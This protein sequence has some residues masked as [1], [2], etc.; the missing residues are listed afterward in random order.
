MKLGKGFKI[1]GDPNLG[2]L[3]LDGYSRHGGDSGS[4]PRLEIAA[5]TN[6]TVATLASL[7]Y[8]SHGL[9]S[10]RV[11][12]GL[13]VGTGTNAAVMMDLSCLHQSKQD[14]IKLPAKV[15]KAH[16]RVMINTEWSLWG[17]IGP[18]KD[19]GLVTKW[20]EQLDRE[21]DDPGFMP[22]EYMTGG[23]YLGEMVRLVAYDYFVSQQKDNP[24]HLPQHLRV[25]AGLH[26]DYLSDVI[27]TDMS[28]DELLSSLERDLPASGDSFRWTSENA[29]MMRSI[30]R[31]IQKRSARLVAAAVVGGLISS[32]D[33]VTPSLNH[34]VMQEHRAAGA[35][36]D[37]IVAF[38]GG[39][40]SQFPHYNQ[41]CQRA[42]DYIVA[43]VSHS[44]IQQR[45]ILREV[46]NGGV[47]GAGI[48]A[49]TVWNLPQKQRATT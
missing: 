8:S 24:E 27:A 30:A 21:G 5:I 41:D 32:G 16:H 49:G 10:T 3:I 40:I 6:D 17:T 20:D 26:T 19:A 42:I 25:R 9:P 38:T 2:R 31:A 11:G 29:E 36:Q 22:F 15:D 28:S 7:A 1:P 46:L 23:R 43:Q 48:L 12:L 33:F 37:L 4:L 14:S 44:D 35:Q 13:I 39:V 34:D 18:V 47:I 45:V